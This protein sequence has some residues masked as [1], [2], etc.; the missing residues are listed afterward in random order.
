[1]LGEEIAKSDTRW[2]T[3][4]HPRT[5]ELFVDLRSA[6]HEVECITVEDRNSKRRLISGPA[7]FEESKFHKF[8]G[9]RYRRFPIKPP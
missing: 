1:M 6:L 4:R 5:S 7:L 2:W 9:L 8:L 3:H